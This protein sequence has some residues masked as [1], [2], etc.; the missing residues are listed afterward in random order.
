MLYFRDR[1]RLQENRAHLGF[2]QAYEFAHDRH[3]L[4]SMAYVPV[5]TNSLSLFSIV[6]LCPESYNLH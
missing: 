5:R 2:I 4:I 1:H 6:S 3:M